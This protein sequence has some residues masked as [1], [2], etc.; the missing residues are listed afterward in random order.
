[1]NQD[2]RAES[3]NWAYFVEKA[4]GGRYIVEL[5]KDVRRDKQEE[6]TVRTG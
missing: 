5:L 1:M 2:R 3:V 6:D 4:V